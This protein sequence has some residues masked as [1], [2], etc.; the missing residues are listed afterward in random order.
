MKVQNNMLGVFS[1]PKHEK[2]PHAYAHDWWQCR[3]HK[4]ALGYLGAA[5]YS[6]GVFTL[7]II[8]R[9]N[10][11]SLDYISIVSLQL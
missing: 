8:A 1:E 3:N 6:E 5:R 2:K 10:S 4:R 11:E 9:I 7:D